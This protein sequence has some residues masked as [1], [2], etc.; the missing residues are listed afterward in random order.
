MFL[1]KI[2]TGMD[3]LSKEDLPLFIC[4]RLIQ[5]AEGQDRTE[6]QRQ[7][8]PPGTRTPSLALH[9]EL[10]VLWL[11]CSGTCTNSPRFIAGELHHRLS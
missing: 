8:Q 11:L 2:G 4:V 9:Q 1:D 3:E 6:R 10:Q 5:W 7:I